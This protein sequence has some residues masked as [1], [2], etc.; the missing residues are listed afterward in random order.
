MPV[1]QSI[2]WERCKQLGLKP[3][4]IYAARICC[5]EYILPGTL[6][7]IW[8]HIFQIR[9]PDHIL[10][11]KKNKISKIVDVVSLADYD[12]KLTENKKNEDKYLARGQ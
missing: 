9:K 4:A 5:S 1:P 6:K 2:H 11:D 3:A 10:I 12:V 8:I 7:C